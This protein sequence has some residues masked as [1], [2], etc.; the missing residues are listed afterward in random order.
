MNRKIVFKVSPLLLIAFSTLITIVISLYFLNSGIFIVFQN[1]FYLP[2][3][4]ASIY[5]SKKGIMFS[6]VIAL[7]YFI[8]INLFTRDNLILA[9]AFLRSLIFVGIS[10]V[11]AL[12]SIKKEK[13]ETAEQLSFQQNLKLKEINEDKDKFF[14]IIAHDLRSPF[15]GLLNISGM[16]ADDVESFSK[17]ELSELTKKMHDTTKNIVTLLKNLLEWSQIQQGTFIL[18]PENFQLKKVAQEDIDSL[19]Q[20]AFQKEININN[21]I[22]ASLIVNADPKMVN[23][24]F[25]N[26]LSNALKFTPRGGEITIDA[27]ENTNKMIQISVKDTGIGM[28]LDIKNN[29]FRIEKNIKRRG[30][31]GEESTGLGL[32]L[33]KEFV[34][35]NGGTIRVESEENEGTNFIFTL[36]AHK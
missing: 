34:E 3:I 28:P 14:S 32:L 9:E 20:M 18:S 33:C 13:A 25:V 11:T 5:Y 23:S 4:I 24:I 16:I 30:T 31:E 19:N 17:E 7:F 26:L 36:P 22:P 35:K 8:L 29:L 2:I 15:Q 12:L 27:I 6:C 10:S 1:L 21:K